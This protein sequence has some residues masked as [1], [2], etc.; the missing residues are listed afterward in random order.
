VELDFAE[1]RLK[2][3]AEREVRLKQNR[4]RRCRIPEGEHKDEWRVKAQQKKTSARRRH[5]HCMKLTELS[6]VHHISLNAGRVR[7]F[8]TI[9]RMGRKGERGKKLDEVERLDCAG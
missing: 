6:E 8:S 5:I 4:N 2:G 7:A 9:E 3:G 1:N